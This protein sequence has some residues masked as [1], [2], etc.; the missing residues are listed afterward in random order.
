MYT[1]VK[2]Q[3]QDQLKG[4]EDAGLRKHE[5]TIVSAQSP[6]IAVEGADGR[7]REV[8]NFCANNYL[9]MADD[10]RLIEAAKAALDE[11]GFGMASVRFICGTQDLHVELESRLS[12]FLGTD[13]TI[14]FSSCFDANGAVFEPLCGPEDAIISDE[15]NHASIID[16]IRLSKAHRLRYRNRDMG[17]LRR[18][19]EEAAHLDDGRGAR[20]TLIVT[21]G[22]F[23]M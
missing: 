4:F 11:R 8:V 1:S 13:D 19:L 22:V 3:L 6:R 21:D 18:C 12:N 17:D 2:Q 9:G 5:R 16:G 10:P 15:L 20:R 7:I 23:S 14:L